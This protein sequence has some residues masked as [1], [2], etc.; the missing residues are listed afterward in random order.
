[1]KP[2][3]LASFERCGKCQL[4][5]TICLHYKCMYANCQLSLLTIIEYSLIWF[6]RRVLHL[7]TAVVKIL[8]MWSPGEEDLSEDFLLNLSPL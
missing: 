7:D 3:D 5:R 2:D 8:Q 6:S 4:H 1:M